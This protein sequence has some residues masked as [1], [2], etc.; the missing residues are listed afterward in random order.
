MGASSTQQLFK[1]QNVLQPTYCLVDENVTPLHED[2][3]IVR[4][5]GIPVV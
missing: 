2:R 3:E 1:E 5:F 4:S